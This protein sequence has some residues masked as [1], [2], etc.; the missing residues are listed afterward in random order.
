M[1]PL[2]QQKDYVSVIYNEKV[3]GNR[4][5]A[6]ITPQVYEVNTVEDFDYLEYQMAKYPELVS[7]FFGRRVTKNEIQ[8]I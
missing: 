8:D 2:K 1:K 3:F 4:V 6:Y 7:R 5:I